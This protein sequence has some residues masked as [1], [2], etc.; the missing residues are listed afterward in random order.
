MAK[1][2][3]FVING[4]TA[5]GKRLVSEK[6]F[7]EWLKPQMKIRRTAQLSYGF[8]WFLQKWNGLKVVQHGGNIDGFN[9]M[10]AM[11]PE[12]KIGFVMLT[13]V[14]AS[15]LGGELMPIVWENILGKPEAPK[16]TTT[17]R[18]TPEKEAGKYK[19]EAA[20]FDFDVK[21]RDGKLIAIVPGQ[22]EYTLENVWGRR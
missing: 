7:D 11:I 3:R 22:P 9:S 14:S 16:L 20:G 13:N 12:K 6:S 8:G 2:L 19:F 21:W 4:G 18:L 1:W 15:P 17:S 10:V 5:D